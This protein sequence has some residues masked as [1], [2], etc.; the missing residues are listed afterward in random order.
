VGLVPVLEEPLDLDE[1]PPLA[2]GHANKA[3]FCKPFAGCAP[4]HPH[5][6]PLE[7]LPPRLRKLCVSTIAGVLWVALDEFRTMCPGSAPRNRWTT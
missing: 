2:P 4:T 5:R 1:G 3:P 6:G 7:D